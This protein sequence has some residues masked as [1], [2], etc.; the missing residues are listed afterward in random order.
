MRI[1]W[2]D[3]YFS[4]QHLDQYH[5]IMTSC[6]NPRQWVW[7]IG[8]IADNERRMYD[9]SSVFYHRPFLQK[10]MNNNGINLRVRLNLIWKLVH[11]V[12]ALNLK[13][14]LH[15]WMTLI[16][17]PSHTKTRPL[18]RIWIIIIRHRTAMSV[19]S[20]LLYVYQYNTRACYVWWEFV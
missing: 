8:M 18:R 2:H 17:K 3:S 19:V 6:I 12:N 4:W 9:A 20:F 5:T 13:I 16:W 14:D 1:L 15:M 11:N 10:W 7:I